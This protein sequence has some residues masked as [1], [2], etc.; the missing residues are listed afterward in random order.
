MA[1]SP[2]P[3]WF[4]IPPRRQGPGPARRIATQRGM[5]ASASHLKVGTKAAAAVIK[6]RAEWQAL[7]WQSF[8]TVGEV[9]YGTNFLGNA[10]SKLGLYVGLTPSSLDQD[11]VPVPDPD[12]DTAAEDLAAVGL[13]AATAATVR[14]NFDRL[15]EGSDGHSELLRKLAVNF[16][17]PGECYLVGVES[18]A[19]GPDDSQI[20]PDDPTVETWTVRSID[21][22]GVDEAGGKLMLFDAPGTAP[23][24]TFTVDPDGNVIGHETVTG[25][26]MTRMWQSHPRW[27]ML[28]DS[29]LRGVLSS[30]EELL[31]AE[32]AT[33]A[34]FRTRMNAGLLLMPEGMSFGGLQETDTLDED[35]TDP[36]DGQLAS[37]LMDPVEDEESGSSL[38]PGVIR[39]KAEHLKEIR[40]LTFD[41]QIDDH[42]EART[43]L[44][45]RRL[46]QGMNI[47][48]EVVTGMGDTNHWQAWLIRDETFTAH[49]EPLALQIVQALTVGWLRPILEAAQVPDPARFTVWY[50]ATAAIVRSNETA[51]AK[52][53]HASGTI[54]DDVFRRALGFSDEDAPDEHDPAVDMA[55]RLVAAAP[56]LVAAP[57]LDVLVAQ[58]RAVLR[59]E[60]AA[61]PAGEM[62]PD[63]EATEQ[64]PP[65]APAAIAASAGNPRIR[66]G[67]GQRLADQDL[68]LRLRVQA[69]ADQALERAV[70]RVGANLRSR[71]RRDQ[72]VAEALNGVG[73]GAVAATLGRR[74]V[75]GLGVDVADLVAG[76]FASV[77]RLFEVVARQVGRRVLASVPGLD[78]PTLGTFRAQQDD[79]RAGARQ[80]LEQAL[81]AFT[82]EHLFALGETVVEGEH[83]GV[84]TVPHSIVREAVARAGG[85][86]AVTAALPQPRDAAFGIATGALAQSAFATVGV[87]VE[88][89][90][91]IYGPYPR[92]TG[93]G[94]HMALDGVRFVNFDDAQLANG[95]GFPSDSHFSPGDHAGCVCSVAPVVFDAGAVAD[96]DLALQVAG[97]TP[98][99]GPN[100]GPS[101][102]LWSDMV[103]DDAA[104]TVGLVRHGGGGYTADRGGW[105]LHRVGRSWQVDRQTR[106]VD[107]TI[108]AELAAVVPGLQAAK[109]FIALA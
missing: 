47:P 94:P 21:E 31:L 16:T 59:G 26:F 22:I 19:A 56:S 69:A 10:L 3:A 75:D 36:F 98:P 86:S 43:N 32:Q 88:G 28:P 29:P 106:H 44:A 81:E 104:A 5:V 99:A 108:T 100:L 18:R 87:Q 55:L 39:G 83:D 63:A 54:R 65:P 17:V 40:H 15:G 48:V 68:Q 2:T 53:A 97:A 91:W 82:A 34:A 7:C 62:A 14:D 64:A 67:L 92:E 105:Y 71:A 42:I 76:Q 46:A 12:S 4:G 50:D 9:K 45:L 60:Q 57:G 103:D 70:A 27:R 35:Q 96:P 89:W 95:G 33:R 84:S 13:D 6:R 23:A 109:T 20:G 24:D 38:V 66:P 58:L 80:W 74:I 25:I 8:D 102:R 49:V 11:A 51:N 78:E 41:R 1:D 93:F 72:S 61:L 107:G 73:N 30:I 101:H 85:Q 52:D 77:G 90:Q 37:V 79:D